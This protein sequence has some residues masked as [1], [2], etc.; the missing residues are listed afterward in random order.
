MGSVAI[1]LGLHT[2]RFFKFICA[3][4]PIAASTVRKRPREGSR[5]ACRPSIVGNAALNL[6]EVIAGAEGRWLRPGDSGVYVLL[7]TPGGC[8]QGSFSARIA[9]DVQ[10]GWGV[11]EARGSGGEHRAGATSSG[12]GRRPSVYQRD[13]VLGSAGLDIIQRRRLGFRVSVEARGLGSG[14]SAISGI[15]RKVSRGDRAGPCISREH[16]YPAPRAGQVDLGSGLKPGETRLGG[17]SASA[18]LGL[19]CDLPARDQRAQFWWERRPT[20][21]F[22]PRLPGS[23]K[24]PRDPTTLGLVEAFPLGLALRV[25]PE[26]RVCVISRLEAAPATPSVRRTASR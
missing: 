23:R 1:S 15:A 14:G 5:P 20:E 10:R 9:E 12:E 21:V 18:D 8:L 25:G 22:F 17:N 4:R 2:G 11:E 13:L 3:A 24:A 19:S 16:E 6:M 26:V 7:A